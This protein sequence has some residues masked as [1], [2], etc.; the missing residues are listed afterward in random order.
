ML[1]YLSLEEMLVSIKENCFP[2]DETQTISIRIL[3]TPEK[4]DIILRIRSGG[5]PFNPIDYYERHRTETVSTGELD[6][7]DG[8]LEGLDDSLGIAMIVAAAPVVDYKTTF[9][10]NN[11]TILL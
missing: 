11:L 5:A 7:L 10:V 4:P 9:G 8:L 6:E 3:L 2:E 1:I